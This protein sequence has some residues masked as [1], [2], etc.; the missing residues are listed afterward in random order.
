MGVTD[1][2]NLLGLS[3]V[4]L[5]TASGGLGSELHVPSKIPTVQIGSDVHGA[6]VMMPLVGFLGSNQSGV[7]MLLAQGA[8]L[9]D[10]ALTYDNEGDI[11]RAVASSGVNR[12]EV[13]IS[14]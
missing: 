2:M 10:T 13:F 3:L 7:Q 6:P 1:T 11:G 4:G 5:L 9:I 8:R 14:T 12:S